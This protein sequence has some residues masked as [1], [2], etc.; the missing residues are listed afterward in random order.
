MEFICYINIFYRFGKKLLEERL[1]D[2]RL[3]MNDLIVIL[4]LGEVGVMDQT[5]LNSF[6]GMDKGNFSN[7]LSRLEKKD[8]IIRQKS[9]EDL[10]KNI[11][12]LTDRS[13]GLLGDLRKLAKSWQDDCMEGLDKSD[14]FLQASK[15]ISFN[16]FDLLG[17][18]FKTNK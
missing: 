2:Y 1:K 3:T 11:C 14:E 16:I 17:I 15:K 4:V 7:F 12:K 8:L 6:V 9:E 18:S 10:K 5:R 13:E